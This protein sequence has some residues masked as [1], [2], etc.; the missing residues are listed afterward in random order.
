MSINQVIISGHLGA[1]V[2]VRDRSGGGRVATLRVC[3]DDGFSN[4]N[5]EWVSRPNWHNAVSFTPGQIDYL[6]RHATS[7]R[8]VTV[9]GSLNYSTYRKEGEDTDRQSVSI[10]IDRVDFPTPATR[11]KE[12]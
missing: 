2:E 10:F 7:G 1:D 11:Q 3:T 9:I 5:N 12:G 8:L 4:D 6:K